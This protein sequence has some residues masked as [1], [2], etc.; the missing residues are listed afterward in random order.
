MNSHLALAAAAVVVVPGPSTA[1]EADL[2]HGRE[3][4]GAL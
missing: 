1:P 2:P 4:A 3:G